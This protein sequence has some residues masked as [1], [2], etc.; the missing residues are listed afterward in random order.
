MNFGSWKID[1]YGI[2][3][4]DM[5]HDSIR[6]P[7]DNLGAIVSTENSEVYKAMLDLEKYSWL[8]VSCL[9]D[10]NS[11]FLYALGYFRIDLNEA[12]FKNSQIM[13]DKAIA[14]KKINQM[15]DHDAIKKGHSRD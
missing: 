11:S 6:I 15:L 10:F 2:S 12:I 8:T 9:H 13:Q 14:I 1:D 5:P 4:L 3:N 7:K